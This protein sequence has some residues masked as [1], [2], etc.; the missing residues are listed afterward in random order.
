MK[1]SDPIDVYDV[2]VIGSGFAGAM[3]AYQLIQAGIRVL[4]LEAGLPL[5]EEDNERLTLRRKYAAS[6]TKSYGSPYVDLVATQPNAS[7]VPGL[8]TDYYIQPTGE[9]EDPFQGYYMRLVGGTGL[10]WLGVAFRM[11]PNDFRMK[12]IY[13]QGRDWPISYDD[14]EPWYAEAEREMGVAGDPEADDLLHAHRS[15]S[16]PMPPIPPS[17]LDRQ[18][19]AAVDGM[20]FEGVRMKVSPTAQ[21]RNSVDGYDGRPACEGYASCVPLCPTKAKYDPL[22]HVRQ[23]LLLGAELRA[24]AVATCLELGANGRVATVSYCHWDGTEKRV[25]ARLFVVAANAIETPKL[26]LQSNHQHPAGL[27]NE[28]GLV[29]RNLMDHPNKLSYALLPHAVHPYRGPQATS[30]IEILRDGAFRSRHGAFRT[31]LRNDG[32][33]FATAAPFG[34]GVENPNDYR[35]SLLEFVGKKK[36]FGADLRRMLASHSSR[37]L[38]LQSVIEMLP[39]FE[40]RVTLSAT[41]QDRFGLP[42]PEFHFRIGDYARKAISA[43]ARLHENIFEALGVPASDMYLHLQK[44]KT[45]ADLGGSHIMGTTVMGEDPKQ[46]VVDPEC[47]A[48]GLPNLY[49]LG[50]SVFPTASAVNPTLTIVA[51]ALRAAESI[52]NQLA[53]Q[54]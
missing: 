25:G 46:S 43:S 20:E 29:G 30:G 47:R 21:A 3:V 38:M 41:Q 39:E 4:M 44:D 26:L 45:A 54:G 9:N 32:W 13:G 17:Y 34:R 7:D 24:G 51:I 52:R 36:M 12:D 27:A 5:P 48:H 11:N 40:N 42:R 18:I 49:I 28:S 50:S 31:A 22:V 19:A 23:A 14:L 2:V 33:R 6:A 10:A 53:Q 15:T 16:F 8:G 37:Q 35:G 1:N